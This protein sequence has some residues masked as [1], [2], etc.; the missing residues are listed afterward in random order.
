MSTARSTGRGASIT[1]SST[2][3]STCCRRRSTSCSACARSA[4]IWA[5]PCRRSI[6]RA[7]CRRRDR[8][9]RSRGQPHRLGGPPGDDPLRDAEEAA[10]LPLRKEP[11]RGGTLRLIDVEDSTCPRAA[12]RT[13][14]EP[15]A[16]ASSPSRRGSGSRAAS[17]SS[18]SAAGARSRGYRMLRDAMRASVRLLSV[19]PEELPAA[20]ERLQ[21]DAKGAEAG[22]RRR[23]RT[24][25][26]AIAP[27]SSP[28]APQ[29][30]A[31]DPR[32]RGDRRCRLVARASTPTRTDSRR[33]RPP[34]RRGRAFLSCW[35]PLRRR[36]SPSSRARPT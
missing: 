10:R 1:C 34:S 5:P 11:A 6:W 21:A 8:R 13:S 32:P 33:W 3:G 31:S 19:L 9:R 15:A 29:R 22:D 25:S 35:S 12:A 23:C 16:S 7:R 4:F 27:T 14:R 28:R 2:P 17:G 26:R 20:I 36:R 30:R 18:S 24:S